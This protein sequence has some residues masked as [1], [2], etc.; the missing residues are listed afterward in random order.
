MSIKKSLKKQ[1][2][3][4]ISLY[5]IFCLGLTKKLNSNQADL[6]YPYN[7]IEVLPFDPHAYFGKRQEEGLKQVIERYKPTIVVEIGSHLGASTRFIAQSLPENGVVYAV[8]HWLGDVSWHFQNQSI[9]YQQFL[10][11]VIHA[12]LCHKI[13]PMRM[14]SLEAAETI[15]AKPDLVFIDG[16]HDYKS[17]Y[18]DLTAWYPHVK[19]HGILCGDDY[20]WGKSHPVKTAVNQFA[21]ENNLKIKLVHNWFWYFER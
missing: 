2:T 5:L 13:V 12:K 8:D 11:N 9:F 7:S 16:S 1:Y 6:P 10:S 21:R 19:V 14:T 18:E 20:H 15:E 3:L 4:I 17:V